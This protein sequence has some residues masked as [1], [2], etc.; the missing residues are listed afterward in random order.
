M[1]GIAKKKLSK[2]RYT[3]TRTIQQQL[4]PKQ[5]A[6]FAEEAAAYYWKKHLA[7][8]LPAYQ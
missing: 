6:L 7:K 4:G 1:L 5:K 8:L 2:E 3:D